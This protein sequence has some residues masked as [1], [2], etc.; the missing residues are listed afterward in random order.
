MIGLREGRQGELHV[1]PRRLPPLEKVCPHSAK[2]EDSRELPFPFFFK[3]SGNYPGGGGCDC[4]QHSRRL[5][6]RL[7]LANRGSHEFGADRTHDSFAEDGVDCGEVALRQGPSGHV[8]DR[9]ELFR[10]TRAPEGNAHARLIEKPAN[11]EMDNTLAEFLAVQK[12]RWT[13]AQ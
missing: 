1:L 3:R 2:T 12:Y 10:V 5:R 7:E 4:A 11:R 9:C 8:L 6:D 13:V